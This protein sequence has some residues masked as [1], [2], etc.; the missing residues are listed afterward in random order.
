MEG[1]QRI[2]M[3]EKENA[4]LKRQLEIRQKEKFI[5][6]DALRL[7]IEQHVTEKFRC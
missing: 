4:E 3:L 1:R 5:P 6:E 2:E 7:H